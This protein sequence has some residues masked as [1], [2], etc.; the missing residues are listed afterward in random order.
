MAMGLEPMWTSI[1]DMLS[2]C[3]DDQLLKWKEVAENPRGSNFRYIETMRQV[4]V[5]M[6]NKSAKDIINELSAAVDDEINSRNVD[7]DNKLEARIARLEKL[8]KSETNVEYSPKECTVVESNVD[9]STAEN[10]LHN[11]VDSIKRAIETASIVR[12]QFRRG[13][14]SSTNW[15]LVVRCLENALDELN[16]AV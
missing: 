5:N 2:S 13:V 14:S 10:D 1:S 6:Y 3:T 12:S 7:M 4:V 8:I 9:E 16:R 11:A 15:N